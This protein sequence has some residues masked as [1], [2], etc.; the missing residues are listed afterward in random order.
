MR[1][2]TLCARCE[3]TTER[4]RA[5]KA[6]KTDGRPLLPEV[7][8]IQFVEALSE[9]CPELLDRVEVK[10]Q[11]RHEPCSDAFSAIAHSLWHEGRPLVATG[12]TAGPSVQ[13]GTSFEDVLVEKCI[14]SA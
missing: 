6:S 10:G 8:S 1:E 13:P 2:A 14:G 5:L 4:T 11:C 12:S 9:P 7:L 3:A